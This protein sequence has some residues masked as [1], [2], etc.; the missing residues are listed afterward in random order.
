[1]L[2]I[3][4]ALNE[5]RDAIWS[6]LEPVIRAGETYAVAQEMSCDDVLAWWFTADHQ[7]FLAEEDRRVIGTY[8][9]RANQKG[10]G[11][12]VANCGYVTASF[13]SGKGVANAMCVHSL[14]QA[15]R[16]GFKAMQFN[17]VVSTNERAVRVWQRNGFEIVG[18]LPAA[19]DHPSAGLVDAYVMHRFL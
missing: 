8:F 15:R 6:I 10:R 17:F 9:L 19:F 12:H 1:M 11:A 14:D 5:D 7:V 3:R 2:T 4:S 18:R 13:A 16:S